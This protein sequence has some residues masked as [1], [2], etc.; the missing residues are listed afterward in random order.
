MRSTLLFWGLLAL[1]QEP[2][3]ETGGNVSTVVEG[4]FTQSVFIRLDIPLPTDVAPLC[5]QSDNAICWRMDEGTRAGARK[6][7]CDRCC[8]E[9][10]ATCWDYIDLSQYTGEVWSADKERLYCCYGKMGP[11][12][13]KMEESVIAQT[14]VHEDRAPQCSYPGFSGTDNTAC[15]KP[16]EGITCDMCCY[17]PDIVP[18]PATSPGAQSLQA[19][20]KC[21]GRQGL[22]RI[23]YKVSAYQVYETCC[24]DDCPPN[25]STLGCTLMSV[26]P[27]L[28]LLVFIGFLGFFC[29][30]E[31][32]LINRICFASYKPVE[33]PQDNS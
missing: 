8:L 13:G 1:A 26:I 18:T 21:W 28:A 6:L 30:I 29:C 5:S 20:N 7:S 12:Y 22:N 33:A 14:A 2:G 11:Q 16:E 3:E 23:N 25:W 32:M 27:Y 10:D 4:D 31:Y 24:F 17:N 19:R 15:W 9:D